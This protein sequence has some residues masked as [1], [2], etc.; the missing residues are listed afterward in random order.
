MSNDIQARIAAVQREHYL[1]DEFNSDGTQMARCRCDVDQP[2][3]TNGVPD[4]GWVTLDEYAAH[5]TDVLMRELAPD[6]DTIA[7]ATAWVDHDHP[8]MP[9]NYEKCSKCNNDLTLRHYCLPDIDKVAEAMADADDI[10]FGLLTPDEAE[11][12][13]R[14]ARAAVAAMGWEPAAAVGEGTHP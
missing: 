12:Y 11:F 6:I 7:E 4:G 3:I 14:M 1:W 13:R 9:R 2:S 5:V 10:I 8:P